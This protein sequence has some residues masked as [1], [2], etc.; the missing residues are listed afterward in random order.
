MAAKR[1]PSA[2]FLFSEEQ[3]ATT[4]AECQA[5]AGPG[6]K[7][8]CLTVTSC[9]LRVSQANTRPEARVYLSAGIGSCDIAGRVLWL[10]LTG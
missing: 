5:A 9:L 3:R 2:Y 4:R 8:C 10:S 1:A 7:A 6:S